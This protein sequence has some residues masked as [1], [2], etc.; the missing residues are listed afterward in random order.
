MDVRVSELPHH[1]K[2][3]RRGFLSARIVLEQN[4]LL[5]KLL[6]RRVKIDDRLGLAPAV[7]FAGLLRRG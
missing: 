1:R 3:P 4:I 2:N 5:Q 6:Q 7:T